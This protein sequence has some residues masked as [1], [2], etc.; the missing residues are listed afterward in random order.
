MPERHYGDEHFSTC[1]HDWSQL[2][3]R[4]QPASLTEDRWL[5]AL[6]E[7]DILPEPLIFDQRERYLSNFFPEAKPLTRMEW[8][9][10]AEICSTW[11]VAPPRTTNSSRVPSECGRTLHQAACSWSSIFTGF[12]L[13][14]LIPIHPDSGCGHNTAQPPI[15]RRGGIRRNQ[16]IE[17]PLR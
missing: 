12:H 17:I 7:K 13:V 2:A 11:T 3:A 1:A 9:A 14:K 15:A 5:R 6:N 10:L 16:G 8:E 4:A